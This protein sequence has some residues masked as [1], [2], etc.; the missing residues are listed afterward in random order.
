MSQQS[1]HTNRH[2]LARDKIQ[3]NSRSTSVT[4][5]LY[6]TFFHVVTT[7]QSRPST[8]QNKISTCKSMEKV[9]EH[10]GTNRFVLMNADGT[11]KTKPQRWG[12]WL[13]WH[14]YESHHI[15]HVQYDTAQRGVCMC[16]CVCVCVCVSCMCTVNLS[17]ITYTPGLHACNDI[18]MM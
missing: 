1:M 2:T 8:I 10:C 18:I 9:V 7:F 16:V 15:C 6:H 5:I 13:A 17:T 11:R 12:S 14:A 4:T 3:W